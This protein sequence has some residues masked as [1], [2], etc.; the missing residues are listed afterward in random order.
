MYPGVNITQLY[1]SPGLLMGDDGGFGMGVGMGYGGDGMESL[2][3]QLRRMRQFG[4]ADKTQ[5]D[6]LQVN[7]VLIFGQIQRC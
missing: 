6:N 1:N 7:F 3:K 5:L 4:V 2:R